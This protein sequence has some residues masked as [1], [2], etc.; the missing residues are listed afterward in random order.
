MTALASEPTTTA[1]A[2]PP[3]RQPRSRPPQPV[4]VRVLTAL[5]S[6]RLTVVLFALAIFLVFVGTLAQVDHDVWFVVNESYFRVWFASVEWQAFA[7]LVEMVTKAEPQPITG[8][9][10]F[11]GGKLIGTLMFANLL[12]AH[13]IRFT[14]AARGVR[15]AVGLG[16]TALGVAATTAVTAAGMDESLQSEL[17]PE[18]CDG[19]WQALRAGL[20]GVSL[21]GAWWSVQSYGRLRP[22]E[23]WLAAACNVALLVVSGWLYA[24]PDAAP[25]PPAMR[26]LWQL[27]KCGVAAALL[28]AG[29]W[30]VFKGRAGIVLLHAGI[31]L[32][33]IGELV[34]D[35]TADE[36]QMRITEGETVNYA[37]DIRSVEL[38]VITDDGG[39]ER[40]TVVPQAMLES[41][42]RSGE[43]ITHPDLPFDVRVVR[44]DVNSVLREPSAEGDNPATAGSGTRLESAPL[45]SAVG[46]GPE[47]GVNLPSAYVEAV[48]LAS[49]D[50]LGVWLVSASYRPVG[51]AG[52]IPLPRQAITVGGASHDVELRL[53]RTYKDYSLTLTDFRFKRY[54]GTEVPKDYSSDLVL[55]DPSRG[56]DRPVRVW[57]NNPLRYAGD[58]LYQSSFDRATERTTVL[59][60]VTNGGWMIPYVSCML[61]G[62]G[63]LSHFGITLGR[64]GRR[65]VE[66]AA[67]DE[68]RQESAEL[69]ASREPIA[70]RSSRVFA[71]LIVGLLATGYFASKARPRSAGGE[72]DVARFAALPVAEG[73]RVKPLDTL[74]RTTLQAISGLQEVKP[75]GESPRLSASRWMLDV[76]SGA[77]GWRDHRVFRVEN[78]ELLDV[79]EL[80]PRKGSYRYSY[81]EL[82]K[83]PDRLD[84]Q[85]ALASEQARQ[86]D[87]AREAGRP[88]E[89][90]STVQRK[91]LELADKLT[92]FRKLVAAFG[93]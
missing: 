31:G 82:T 35:L 27:T 28:L 15:L 25:D 34:T 29:C 6:L 68:K 12:A 90:L 19:L 74:A 48:D 61:V 2:K 58:T 84:R 91:T 5:A 7:R 87:A 93:S 23:W 37:Y 81:S 22:A 11:P 50:P 88:A 55:T 16:V 18:L 30:V 44:F 3:A 53:K 75:S 59:Q 8:G 46:V 13:T 78:L 65:R 24:N 10:W 86:V 67:R 14:V 38:A 49:G 72:F 89:P 79:L 1:A 62:I 77:D 85:I 52:G 66:E 69:S 71:P 73:G 43:P 64:F 45:R 21:L 63:M 70:W 20:A 57:M 33:M 42:A 60:V 17:S 32:L 80:P 51:E 26:I 54:V 39:A 56:V 9:F 83:N 41:S 92:E 47:M 76:V 40:V 36:A 4:G